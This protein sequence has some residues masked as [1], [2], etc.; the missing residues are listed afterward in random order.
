MAHHAMRATVI[1]V[2]LVAMLAVTGV[3]ATLRYG[4][5]KHSC[6]NVESI[7]YKAMKA[8]Y[9][10]DNTV[11]PGVLRLIFHD[12]FVR[13]RMQLNIQVFLIFNI[14]IFVS[15]GSICRIRVELV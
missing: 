5:Y 1:A 10:K 11:A 12:C 2:V 6:P 14:L 4:F 8:A 13:V 7:I 15:L 9:E 3:D